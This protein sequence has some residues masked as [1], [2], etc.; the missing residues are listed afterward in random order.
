MGGHGAARSVG[1]LPAEA[2][3]FVGRRQETAAVTRLLDDHRLLTLTGGAGVGKT[4]LALR[5][6]A[7]VAHAFRDGA[8]LVEMGPLA[9]D[10]FVAQ[11]VAEAFGL[12]QES[13]QDPQPVLAE[14]LAGKDLL[15]VLDNCEHVV[16]ACRR[17]VTDLLRTSARLRILVTS[18]QPLHVRGEWLF[19]VPPL[20]A[21]LEGEQ[22]QSAVQVPG[23]EAVRLF[24]ERAQAALPGFTVH[25]GNK[26]TIVRLCARLGGIPLAIELAAVQVRAV[27]PERILARLEEHYW[28]LLGAGARAS[29]PRLQTLQASID[30]S[31]DLCSEQEQRVWGR[32]SAFRGGFDLEAAR[33]VCSG[34]GVE[35]GEMLRLIAGLANKS[36][37]TRRLVGETGRYGMLET[38]REYG[39]QRLQA[40]GELLVVRT[41]HRDH[42]GERARQADQRLLSPAELQIY[43][44]LSRDHANLRAALELCLT[45]PGEAGTGL[46]IAASLAYYWVFSGHHREG[47]F[48]LDRA[49]AA[50]PEPSPARAKALWVN[51]WLAILQGDP[52]A[53]R[54]LIDRCR[55]LAR[56]TGDK[57]AW[58]YATQIS[59]VAAVFL[60]GHMRRALAL[61]TDALTQLRALGDRAGVW[62]TLLHLMMSAAVL[63]DADRAHSFGA[64]CVEMADACDGPLTRPWSLGLHGFAEWLIDDRQRATRLVRESL[65]TLPSVTV[66]HWGVAQL[67]EVL[68]WDA[69]A[70]DDAERA[71]RLLGSAHTSWLFT[72]TPLSALPH[73]VAG[74]ARCVQDTSAALGKQRF[75]TL[76]DEG[77]ALTTDR[78]IAYARGHTL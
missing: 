14:F 66:F 28:D 39:L 16:E 41:R 30:S 22:P 60:D 51:A 25:T 64:Q 4:R 29:L 6:A 8:W 23:D 34:A 68:A 11:R 63:G 33:R 78:A 38:I 13:T 26:N 50:D 43:E 54:L 10:M 19:D 24:A 56:Q 59:G 71:A 76:Y 3:S 49:L 65:A 55:R 18:R 52:D 67:L 73:V 53:A 27:P 42:F 32:A 21:A 7:Q 12:R 77:A 61:L 36:V 69:A 48:W 44:A 45:E 58:A 70:R 37:L 31:F 20:S 57:T 40:S 35:P 74:H 72:A 75:R 47:R 1:N 9:D 15:L 62:Y 46:E 17:L 2:T 5:V